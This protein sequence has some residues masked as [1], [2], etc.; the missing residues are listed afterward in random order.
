[1]NLHSEETNELY[2]LM[3]R[4][5]K[6]RGEERINLYTVENSIGSARKEMVDGLSPEV[7]DNAV[8]VHGDDGILMD[9]QEMDQFILDNVDRNGKNIMATPINGHD[10]M[11]NTGKLQST[12]RGNSPPKD[13]TVGGDNQPKTMM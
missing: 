5:I 11:R 8:L 10:H 7:R 1:M 9:E 13:P 4:H 2:N 6:K 12:S 3:A